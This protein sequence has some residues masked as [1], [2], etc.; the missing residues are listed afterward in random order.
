MERATSIRTTMLI[1]LLLVL[2]TKTMSVPAPRPLCMSQFALANHA[3][4]FVPLEHH[5]AADMN[6]THHQ[7]NQQQMVNEHEHEHRHGHDHDHDHDHDHEHR[8]DHDHDHEHR[9]DHDHDRDHEHHRHQ[10]HRHRH[11]HHHGANAECCRWVRELDSTCVC[12]L[13]VQLPLFLRRSPHTYTVRVEDSC[14]VKFEC[15][16]RA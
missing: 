11:H 15:P 7:E 3:C 1:L 13:M 5:L 10:A 4:A 6:G 12:Q 2:A 9:H 8:H 16:G 14:Q